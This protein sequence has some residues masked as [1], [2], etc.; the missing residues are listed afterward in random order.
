MRTTTI[1]TIE[2]HSASRY[3]VLLCLCGGSIVWHHTVHLI[4]AVMGRGLS[5]RS[6][7]MLNSFYPVARLP[8]VVEKLNHKSMF[9]SLIGRL[10]SWLRHSFGKGIEGLRVGLVQKH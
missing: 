9:S 4:V 8:V 3:G 5:D 6:V 1:A 7:Q 2:A 10:I